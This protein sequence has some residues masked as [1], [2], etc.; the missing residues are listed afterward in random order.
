MWNDYLARRSEP[1]GPEVTHMG[2][3]AALL[4][5]WLGCGLALA[6]VLGSRLFR[7]QGEGK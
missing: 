1:P 3:V 2:I 6:L 5:E 7:G 4:V